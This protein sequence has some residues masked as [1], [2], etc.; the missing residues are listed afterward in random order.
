M[1][2]SKL[3][4]WVSQLTFYLRRNR[5]DLEEVLAGTD[6]GK[7]S[8][9]TVR[10]SLAASDSLDQ[11][12]DLLCD[13]LHTQTHRVKMVAM[14]SV[15]YRL[16]P[17]LPYSSERAAAELPGSCWR[18]QRA[19]RQRWSEW[20]QQLRVWLHSEEKGVLNQL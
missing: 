15:K 18:R 5:T 13:H 12:R 20:Q 3:R 17:F 2:S 7:L 6:E 14:V 9:R 16:W 19:E 1:V 11:L 8:T 4:V 10:L